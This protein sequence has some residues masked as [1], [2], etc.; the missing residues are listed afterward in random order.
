M[1]TEKKKSSNWFTWRLSPAELAK[2]VD[3]YKTLNFTQS[4]RGITV[5][6]IAIIL[7]ITVTLA[8]IGFVNWVDVIAGAILYIPVTFFAYR[9]HRWAFIA[10]IVLW[11][12]DKATQFFLMAESGKPSIS[13]IIWWII[14]IPLFWKGLTVEIAR[15]K[16]AASPNSIP[17]T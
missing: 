8:A 9:G 7:C 3:E 10:L 17:S 14:F 13:P 11:T 15:R 6:A 16:K 2:Q 1:D 4:Y 12:G 5:L